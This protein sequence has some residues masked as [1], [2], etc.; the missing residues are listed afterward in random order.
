M[1]TFKGIKTEMTREYREWFAEFDLHQVNEDGTQGAYLGEVRPSR[2]NYIG[3]NV[4]M[5]RWTTEKDEVFMWQGNVY[6]AM[7]SFN[8]KLITAE[9]M[10]HYNP[11]IL[12]MWIGGALLLLGVF[13]AI[14]PQEARYQ[15][16][17]AARRTAQKAG[18]QAQSAPQE[19]ALA[20]EGS[21]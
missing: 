18:A 19:G 2:R 13:V 16:F 4:K 7:V 17:A 12:W 10:A 20:R 5:S 3:A 1:L 6:L 21:A 15:V 14:W 8:D 9:V 11:M